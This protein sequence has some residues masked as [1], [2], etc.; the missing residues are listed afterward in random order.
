MFICGS[1]TGIGGL[2]GIAMRKRNMGN[3]PASE[4]NHAVNMGTALD[5][6]STQ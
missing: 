2:L 1:I 5:A 3:T 6:E 4:T